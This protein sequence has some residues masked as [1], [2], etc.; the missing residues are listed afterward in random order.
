[1]AIVADFVTLD[2][3]IIRLTPGGDIDQD[4]PFELS[5]PPPA[6]RFDGAVLSFMQ[7]AST[8]ND[9]TFTMAVNGTTVLPDTRVDS[10]V[11]H[12]VHERIPVSSLRNGPNMLQIRVTGGTGT[13]RISDPVVFY[14]RNV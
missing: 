8:P 5:N 7:D 13:L 10:T 14:H 4:V 3:S 11:L 6:T 12:A 2:E 1:M 9:L